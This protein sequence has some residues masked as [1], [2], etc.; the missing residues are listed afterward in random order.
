MSESEER[1][2]HSKTDCTSRLWTAGIPLSPCG[3]V[4]I[5]GSSDKK[6]RSPCRRGALSEQ[7]AP[8]HDAMPLRRAPPGWGALMAKPNFKN[9]TI[10]T[11]DNLDI[12]RGMN[13]ETVDLIY[14]DPPFNSNRSFEAPIGSS[15][16]G[17]EFK[18]IWTLDDLDL[19]WHGEIAE[20]EPALYSVLDAA[21]L[22]HGKGMKAYLIMMAVRL[23]EIKRVLKATGSIYLHCDDTASHY[24]KQVMD[25]IFGQGNFRNE[26]VWERTIGRSDAKRFARVHDIIL[27]YAKSD[28][29]IWN[30]SWQPLTKQQIE[31][32]YRYKDD[33]G[34]FQPTSLTTKGLTGGGYHYDFHGK[35]GPWRYPEARMMQLEAEGRIWL[36]PKIGGWPRY[37]RYVHESRGVAAR[38]VVTDISAAGSLERTGYPTQ[39]P[40]ALLKRI[41]EASSKPGDVVLDPFCGCATACVAAEDFKDG[42]KRNWVG[43]DVS[44]MAHA[45]VKMRLGNELGLDSLTVNHREDVPRRTDLGNIPPYNVDA[46]K[47]HLYGAQEG[48]CSGCLTLFP[49]RNLTIDHV[50]PRAKGGTDHIKNLQLLCQ[51][52]NST[53]GTGTQE[54]LLAKLRRDGIRR[55]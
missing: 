55:D 21:G 44:P 36:P 23:L 19:A 5:V 31:R 27:Y 41:I 3:L 47:R 24:L 16:E 39:K 33:A 13:S 26:I 18:D 40:L 6:S 2:F 12:L 48:R 1:R 11:G 17:A 37:K 52:C 46:N 14:L 20:K 25:S 28:A 8:F 53:K 43:I 7:S 9:R 22:S 45:L 51:A 34:R 35:E 32:D 15:A 42:E 30:G 38:D 54:A 29:S 4:Q 50:V 10:W 49:Y